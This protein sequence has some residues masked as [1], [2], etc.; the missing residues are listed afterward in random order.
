MR[1][2]IDHFADRLVAAGRRAVPP[3]PEGVRRVRRAALGLGAAVSL[4]LLVSA[5]G[6]YYRS[7]KLVAPTAESAPVPEQIEALE[8]RLRRAEPKGT[9]LAVDIFRNRLRVLKGGQ[10]LRDAPCSSGNRGVLRDLTTGRMWAFDTPVGER[11]V[12][13]KT[14]NPVWIKPDWAFIEEGKRPP[15]DPRE[16]IDRDSLG[17]HAL[18][19]GDG[20][21]IH[22]TLF[23]TLIGQSVTH[24]C[25]RLADEDLNYVYRHIPVGAR[26]FLY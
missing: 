15:K 4:A 7:A 20:Y 26:V 11:K 1:R 13:R 12:E 10:V 16:R 19:L 24:G 3:G 9:Y 21:L 6:G 2:S 14:A 23:Q 22:G 17:T 8:R 5:H 25:I 18:Y